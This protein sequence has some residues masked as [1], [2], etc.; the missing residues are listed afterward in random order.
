[1]EDVQDEL[2][3]R[4]TLGRG[5]R[6]KLAVPFRQAANV[7]AVGI[8]YESSPA[9][10]RGWLEAKGFAPVTVRSLGVLTGAQLFSLNKDE[11]KT[12]C[13]DD[14]A[15]VFSQV[16][17]QKAALE[18][19]PKPLSDTRSRVLQS[20]MG[21]RRCRAE[22]GREEKD[23]SSS[24]SLQQRAP[25]TAITQQV[26]SRNRTTSLLEEVPITRPLQASCAHCM[27]K[28]MCDRVRV[29]AGVRPGRPRSVF[30]RTRDDGFLRQQENAHLWQNL[31]FLRLRQQLAKPWGS[32]ATSGRGPCTSTAFPSSRPIVELGNGAKRR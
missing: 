21:S 12:V 17:V 19:T 28:S 7:P 4:L 9:D 24:S 8:T 20:I 13:P 15:R 11:L 10:V 25:C 26:A 2:L 5:A 23:H 3:H 6:K 16:A 31:H 29:A 14:G 22:D 27:L 18:R 30:A 32:A 1:M